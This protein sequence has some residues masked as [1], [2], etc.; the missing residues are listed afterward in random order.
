M[1]IIFLNALLDEYLILSSISSI[2]FI[3]AR[4]KKLERF[5]IYAIKYNQIFV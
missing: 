5:Q 4:D 3:K 2:D 1:V